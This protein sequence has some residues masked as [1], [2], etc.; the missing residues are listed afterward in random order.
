MLKSKL[1]K[2]VKLMTVN[3]IKH[4]GLRVNTTSISRGMSVSKPLEDAF[5][6]MKKNS[7]RLKKRD[8]RYLHRGE[9][10]SR[11]GEW[12]DNNSRLFKVGDLS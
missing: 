12:M 3:K 2:R 5:C 1:I 10:S 8:I 4:K 11:L 7:L 6:D 9:I